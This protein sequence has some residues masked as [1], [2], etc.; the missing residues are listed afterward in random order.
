MPFIYGKH[1]V[2]MPYVKAQVCNR[3]GK[4]F[5]EAP[6]VLARQDTEGEQFTSIYCEF[7]F[8]AIVAIDKYEP[9]DNQLIDIGV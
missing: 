9:S 2:P 7:C 8:E 3:C 4:E 6:A 1:S 5:E